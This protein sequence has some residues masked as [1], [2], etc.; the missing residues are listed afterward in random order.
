M[1]QDAWMLS[2]LPVAGSAS[3]SGGG[4]PPAAPPVPR[5]RPASAAL[6]HAGTQ[7]G[8]QGGTVRASASSPPQ[9][10]ASPRVPTADSALD[11]ALD[12]AVHKVAAK[13]Q[14]ATGA[15]LRPSPLG[16]LY[17]CP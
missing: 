3:P 12:A 6:Q 9:R 2:H 14:K 10:L 4:R 15:P 8:G 13:Q 1:S 16:A 17:L 5:M 7:P 11:A